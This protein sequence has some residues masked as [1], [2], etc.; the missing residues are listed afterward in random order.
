MK[1]EVDFPIA[2]G[3]ILRN[4]R[5]YKQ[6]FSRILR[7]LREAQMRI[8][9]IPTDGCFRLQDTRIVSSKQKIGKVEQGVVQS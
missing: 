8:R 4:I 1:V 7:I 5:Q 3:T 9:Q 2:Q 6:L